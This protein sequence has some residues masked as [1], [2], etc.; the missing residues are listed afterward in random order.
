VSGR[1]SAGVWWWCNGRQERWRWSRK[2]RRATEQLVGRR[3]S[4]TI[5]AGQ[6]QRAT[7][8]S[9]GRLSGYL[10]ERRGWEERLDYELDAAHLVNIHSSR[11]EGGSEALGCVRRRSLRTMAPQILF[12]GPAAK[13]PRPGASYILI[14]LS[15]CARPAPAWQS[16]SRTCSPVTRLASPH[17]QPTLA[18]KSLCWIAP[19]LHA[20]AACSRLSA[21]LTMNRPA[22]E[23]ASTAP[24][25]R[26]SR[27]TGARAAWRCAGHAPCG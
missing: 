14:V 3:A 12:D 6:D 4:A 10:K 20:I 16:L 2:E 24:G 23:A 26:V 21:S 18:A 7:R 27:T 1:R 17:T 15:H 5:A 22:P 11:L 9:D 25:P 13:P 8:S 19:A